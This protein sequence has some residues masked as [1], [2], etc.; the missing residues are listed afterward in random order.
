MS[1]ACSIVEDL[2]Q[3]CKRIAIRLVLSRYQKKANYDLASDSPV[4]GLR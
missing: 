1:G 3:V 2:L 4:T